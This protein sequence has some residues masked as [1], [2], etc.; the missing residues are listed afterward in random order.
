MEEQTITVLMPDQLRSF[1]ADR[2]RSGVCGDK[3]EYLRDP[4]RRNQ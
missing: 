2:V 3:G 1:V 4:V